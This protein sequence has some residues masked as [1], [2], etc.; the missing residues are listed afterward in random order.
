MSWYMDLEDV[1]ATMIEY[2]SS[3]LKSKYPNIRFTTEDAERRE[4]SFPTVRMKVIGMPERGRD[5]ENQTVNGV[6]LTIQV[7][8]T[9]NKNKQEAKDIAFTIMEKFKALHF[10]VASMP[11]HTQQ[12]DVYRYISRVSRLVAQGDKLVL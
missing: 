11:L 3:E 1:V 8:V 6:T 7:D 4:A 12:G 9:S 5:L 10:N 2:N